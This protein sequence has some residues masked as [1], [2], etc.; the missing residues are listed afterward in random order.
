MGGS[1]FIC[2]YKEEGGLSELC[3]APLT[4]SLHL[5]A[6]LLFISS[7]VTMVQNPCVFWGLMN[8]L[9]WIHLLKLTQK[10]TNIRLHE[11]DRREKDQVQRHVAKTLK[12]MEKSFHEGEVSN[13][14][15]H[16][17]WDPAVVSG[18]YHCNYHYY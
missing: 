4:V 17:L 12:E 3:C 9:N 6:F 13:Y 14:Y 1:T 10:W 16:D 5:S 15:Y 7:P 8:I 18:N 2:R 11:K